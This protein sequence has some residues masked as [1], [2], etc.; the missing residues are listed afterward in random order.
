[1][2]VTTS[3]V[4][5]SLSDRQT[6]KPFAAESTYRWSPFTYTAMS[7]MSSLTVSPPFSAM[8]GFIYKTYKA[9]VFFP[10]NGKKGIGCWGGLNVVLDE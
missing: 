10:E 3:D 8:I 6:L 5:F 7:R 2:G 1:M 9:A 4:I